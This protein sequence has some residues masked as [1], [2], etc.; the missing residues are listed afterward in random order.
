MVIM[1]KNFKIFN[2]KIKKTRVWWAG[3]IEGMRQIWF[4]SPAPQM[5]PRAEQIGVIL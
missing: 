5:V 4:D 2:R 3:T 1:D